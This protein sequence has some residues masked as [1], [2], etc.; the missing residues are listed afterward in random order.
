MISVAVTEDELSEVCDRLLALGARSIDVVAPGDSRRVVLAAV[1]ETS[2]AGVAASLRAGGAM[3]VT[4]PN[5]GPP[6][7]K[8]LQDT[9]PV[10]FDGR[11]TVCPAWSEHD[12]RR[13]PGLV[14]LGPGG[15]GNGRHPTTRQMIEELLERTVGGE[16]VLDVGCGSGILALAALEIGAASAVAVDIDRGAVAAARRNADINGLGDRLEA[17]PAPLGAIDGTFDVVLA[18][19][20]RAGIVELA[21][22]LVSHLAPGGWLAVGGI[23]PSQCEQA[24]GFLRP[25]VEAGRRACGEWATLVL[26][27]RDRVGDADGDV[28]TRAVLRRRDRRLALA[29]E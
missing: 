12:R 20:A 22:E 24:A 26:A 7:R 21:P 9:G 15:F 25:L 27:H 23:S 13:L 19:I 4:R 8:W 5:G 1:D 17:T 11:L 10:T 14:E 6:L 28:S 16:R 18:N 29:G 2:A 3:A